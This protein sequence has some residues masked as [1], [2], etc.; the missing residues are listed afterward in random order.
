MISWL[1]LVLVQQE[2]RVLQLEA[3]EH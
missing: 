1:G 2:Q 3:L